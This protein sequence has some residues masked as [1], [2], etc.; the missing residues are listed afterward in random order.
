MFPVDAAQD[1]P[2]LPLSAYC[3]LRVASRCSRVDHREAVCGDAPLRRKALRCQPGSHCVVRWFR[4]SPAVAGR[5]PEIVPRPLC[6]SSQQP[7]APLEWAPL[8]PPGIVRS[9][10]RALAGV[11]QLAAAGCVVDRIVDALR[12]NRRVR[13]R[14]VTTGDAG[15]CHTEQ[16]L[17]ALRRRAPSGT[18]FAFGSCRAASS[19]DA[20]PRCRHRSVVLLHREH[21][22]GSRA[23]WADSRRARR[24]PSLVFA[25]GSATDGERRWIRRNGRPSIARRRGASLRARPDASTECGLHPG[26]PQRLGGLEPGPARVLIRQLVGRRPSGP[27]AGWRDPRT[28]ILSRRIGAGNLWFTS[29][30][31]S[32][33]RWWICLLLTLRTERGSRFRRGRWT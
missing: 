16:V 33:L 11:H 5:N 22:N 28:G 15:A 29:V 23:C 20:G 31:G 4:G 32:G 10:S 2:S 19:G 26:G 18:G 3:P 27:R 12:L 6:G 7:A 30:L 9:S 1:G 25:S 24:R 8:R 21:R 17:A 13:T 14:S